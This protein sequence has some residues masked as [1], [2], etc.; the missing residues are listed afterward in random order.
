MWE[1]ILHLTPVTVAG[2][3]LLCAALPWAAAA[4]NARTRDVALPLARVLLTLWLLLVL[5]VTLIPDQSLNSG[6]S[7]YINWLP[8]EGLWGGGVSTLGVGDMERGMIVRLQLANAMMFVP[9][10]ALY[11]FA[12]RRPRLGRAVVAC[13]AL[14]VLIEAVQY[15]MNA[16]RTVDVDDVLFNTFGGL[17]G[18][19]LAYLPYRTLCPKAPPRH[20][21]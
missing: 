7:R 15:A 10:G 14:S 16:G 21:S 6:G 11:V 4:W 12:G 1:I 13:L 20:A 17:V 2:F 3:L 18:S 9:L 5:A 8:G 19:L